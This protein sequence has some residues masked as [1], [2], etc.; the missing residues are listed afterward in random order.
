M[1]LEYNFAL[2]YL[3]HNYDNI[4]GNPDLYYDITKLDSISVTITHA[5]AAAYCNAAF[6]HIYT[7]VSNWKAE[8]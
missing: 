4:R 5:F 2:K 3:F 8:G 1:F 6:I 7:C